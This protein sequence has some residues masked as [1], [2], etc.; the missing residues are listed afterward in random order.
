MLLMTLGLERRVSSQL[1]SFLNIN[2]SLVDDLA[3]RSTLLTTLGLERRVLVIAI[4]VP[5]HQSLSQGRLDLSF[6]T[7]SVT[8]AWAQ[9]SHYSYVR[10]STSL[11]LGWLGLL[12]MTLGL[13]R[14]VSSQLSSFLNTNISFRNRL[15]FNTSNDTRA[16][17]QSL[18]TAPDHFSTPISLNMS[19]LVRR[20]WRMNSRII[21]VCISLH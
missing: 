5:Q 16:W 19:L 13:E 2:L 12:L 20:F 9:S 11:S 10:S 3:S 18:V 21:E 6:N 8:R 7:A 15:S 17:V 1:R 14:R 4:F